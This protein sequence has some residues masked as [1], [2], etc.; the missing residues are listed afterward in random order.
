[1]TSSEYPVV[2]TVDGANAGNEE[3]VDANVTVVNTMYQELLNSE[4]IAPNALRSFFVDFYLAQS[5]GGGF[6]QY[7]FTAPERE[8]VDAYIR[9]GLE[10]MGAAAHLELYDRT[11]EAF[12]SL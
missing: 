5:L 2:L 3:V 1:M 4:E 11:V 10:G 7:V 12:E 6:A 8:E 9:E